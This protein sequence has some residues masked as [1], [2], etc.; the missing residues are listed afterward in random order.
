[1]NSESER[2]LSAY[3]IA[4]L[5]PGGK[6][7]D[8]EM[9]KNPKEV[10]MAFLH[11][12]NYDFNKEDVL[13]KKDM[14]LITKAF[15]VAADSLCKKIESGYFKCF[16]LIGASTN[17]WF[18]FEKFSPSE[19]KAMSSLFKNTLHDDFYYYMKKIK[20]LNDTVDEFKTCSHSEL[21]I[22]KHPKG[23]YTSIICNCSHCKIG[24]AIDIFSRK[25]KPQLYQSY[26][27]INLD[28][29]SSGLNQFFEIMGQDYLS[30]LNNVLNLMKTSRELNREKLNLFR[31]KEKKDKIGYSFLRTNYGLQLKENK[32]R[33]SLV[34]LLFNKEFSFHDLDTIEKLEKEV[35]IALNE[36]LG[37]F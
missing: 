13:Y 16:S 26:A 24:F 23:G 10:F 22:G 14:E 7:V 25:I 17:N 3:L 21:N 27:E 19:M 8:G 33:D 20:L 11:S 15:S 29:M 32:N 37:N 2:E 36:A 12:D 4:N 6:L 30:S 9:G 18:G 35:Q 28:K 1:M 31:I 5:V 34:L